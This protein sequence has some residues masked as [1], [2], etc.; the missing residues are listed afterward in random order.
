MEKQADKQLRLDGQYKSL[1]L[2]DRRKQDRERRSGDYQQVLSLFT[3]RYPFYV[4]DQELKFPVDDVLLLVYSELFDPE[5][6]IPEAGYHSEIPPELLG[7][8]ML[9][10]NFV[11]TFA[12]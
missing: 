12:D 5:K 11:L 8:F 7:D 6:K 10:E 2:T 9:V 3:S 4:K 1:W